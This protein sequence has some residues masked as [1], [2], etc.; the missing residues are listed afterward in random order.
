MP[1]IADYGISDHFLSETGEAA[2]TTP[3]IKVAPIKTTFRIVRS[4]RLGY[5]VIQIT[6]HQSEL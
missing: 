2:S 1:D 5:G 6:A 4:P 3:P